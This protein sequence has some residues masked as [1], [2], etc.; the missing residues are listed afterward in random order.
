MIQC[1][2][3]STI[4]AQGSAIETIEVIGGKNLLA[5]E[6][7][8]NV[9]IAHVSK[10][11][12]LGANNTIADWIIQVPGVSLNGQGGLYQS[13]SIRGLSRWR[14][15]T[16]VNGIVLL[17]DRRAGNSASF[18]DPGLLQLA[19]V[20]KGP[21]AML[22]GSEAIGGVISMNSVQGEQDTLEL[23]Y[24]DTGKGRR[25]LAITGE[26]HYNLA[27][28]Y[29]KKEKSYAPNGDELNNGFEQFSSSLRY[30]HTLTNGI[31]LNMS[32]LPSISKDVGKNSVTFP[33]RQIAV[34]PEDMHSL[35]QL[36]LNSEQWFVN[37]FHHYQ[38]WDSDVTRIGKRHNLTQYQSHTLG[39]N[40]YHEYDLY[41]L[42]LRA[43][44]DWT[45]RRGVSITDQESNLKDASDPASSTLL[46]GTQDNIAAFIN[47]IWEDN[48]WRVD[49]GA[50][51]DH[52]S[53]SNFG[54]SKSDNHISHSLGVT[55][56]WQ[57]HSLSLNYASAFRFPTLT[58]LY[59]NGVTPR[60]NT[61]GNLELEPETSQ[62]LELTYRL[63]KDS[64]DT[65]VNLFHTQL[66]DYIERV[67]LVSGDRT[68]QNLDQAT[69]S[70]AEVSTH[71][72]VSDA[73]SYTFGYT[74]QQG[75]SKSGAYL[76]DISPS[77]LSLSGRYVWQSFE[78]APAVH[79]QLAKRNV[80]SGEAALERSLVADLNM[81]WYMDESWTLRAGVLN[82]FNRLHR[83]TADE[84]APYHAERTIKLDI[85]WQI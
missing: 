85:S 37:V 64:I 68:Y 51:F 73:L 63:K 11:D 14:V 7:F 5:S 22:Y 55:K 76:A 84:D 2:L 38:N 61:L 56:Q 33:D 75:K 35:A 27:F 82:L 39:T 40:L 1:L 42:P 57:S 77:K 47:G 20:Q 30:Q 72:E 17:T 9:N 16:E 23:G 80:G 3:L 36:S 50:R 13:Y 29:R 58:E 25:L 6:S 79:Y 15:R 74:H 21:A 18:I 67:K 43:G 66:D 69:I 10:D 65:T 32:W 83:T 48:G 41:G 60:G 19:S 44:L 8:T 71:I 31:E 52:F 53:A 81:S 4:A 54:I 24:E 70:G 26:E 62:G 45:A 78:F 46:D 49:F 28:A 12:L 59:F 34:Y